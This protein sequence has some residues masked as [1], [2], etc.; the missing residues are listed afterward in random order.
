MESIWKKILTSKN[1]NT[2]KIAAIKVEKA[3]HNL[4][5]EI[6]STHLASTQNLSAA[7]PKYTTYGCFF[8]F[9]QGRLPL[10]R[11]SKKSVL[12]PH[13]RFH[14]R[15]YQRLNLLPRSWNPM[16]ILC[17]K[18]IFSF[19]HR[20]QR[21]VSRAF[22]ESLFPAACRDIS[23]ALTNGVVYPCSIGALSSSL[24]STTQ[25]LSPLTIENSCLAEFSEFFSGR[26][27]RFLRRA[28]QLRGLPLHL[29]RPKL[30]C[31][32]SAGIAFFPCDRQSLSR[33]IT[34]NSF[35]AAFSDFNIALTNSVVYLRADGVP[36]FSSA[37]VAPVAFS[38]AIGTSC[39]A[40]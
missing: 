18:R 11:K 25:S 15:A 37:Q 22:P 7:H 6:A 36:H 33:G 20:C 21:F 29:W 19:F 4:D 14:R 16:L 8:C 12:A 24:S 35:L 23:V 2:C 28:H 40:E 1:Q 17:L 27:K 39:I 13:W 3:Q 30:H 9:L 32:K 26:K 34:E 38:L 31:T 5:L 10:S